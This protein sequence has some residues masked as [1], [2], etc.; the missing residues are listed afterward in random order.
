M[1]RECNADRSFTYGSMRQEKRFHLEGQVIYS[2]CTFPPVC[3]T[4]D[5]NPELEGGTKKIRNGIRW[6]WGDF[7]SMK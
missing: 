4:E 3:C 2:N 1:Y 5:A 7:F 6:G